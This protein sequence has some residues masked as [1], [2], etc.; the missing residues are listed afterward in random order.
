MDK[1][2]VIILAAGDSSRLGRPKQL[3]PFSDKTLLAKIVDEALEAALTPVVVVTGAYAAE[4]GDS[5]N[6]RP[7]TVAYN[8]R[9]KEGMASGIVAGLA[10]LLSVQPRMR[11]VVIAVCDQPRLSAAL[12]AE[13]VEQFSVSRKGIVA[14]AYGGTVGTPVLFGYRYFRSLSGLSGAEGAKKLLKTYP[15]DVATVPFPGG[16]MDID[17]EEDMG[18]LF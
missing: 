15:E 11:G 7:V 9:W 17:T 3:L 4:V 6:G 14:C 13:L 5:I 16:E 1:I 18:K 12:L 2:G 10:E 8:S